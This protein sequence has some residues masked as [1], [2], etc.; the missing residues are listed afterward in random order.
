M[1]NIRSHSTAPGEQYIPKPL[2]KRP[3][4]NLKSRI[5]F[6]GETTASTMLT[7]E[8]ATDL[9][10][11]IPNIFMQKNRDETHFSPIIKGQ[12]INFNQQ[13]NFKITFEDPVD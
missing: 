4:T 10:R 13:T 9:L 3:A 8:Q 5:P 12:Q 7:V 2:D 6:Q 1:L 11:N